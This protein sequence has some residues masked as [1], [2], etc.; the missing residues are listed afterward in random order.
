M[1]VKR[2]WRERG[3][4]GWSSATY[5][6]L[7]LSEIK[8]YGLYVLLSSHGLETISLPT[9]QILVISSIPCTS[10]EEDVMKE[11]LNEAYIAYAAH[12]RFQT[13]RSSYSQMMGRTPSSIQA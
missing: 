12:L 8:P 1:I 10:V 9:S 13:Q 5:R 6:G 11:F 7:F 3:K 2:E 4:E